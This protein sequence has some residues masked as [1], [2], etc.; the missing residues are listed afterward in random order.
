VTADRL[1]GEQTVRPETIEA[2]A[3]PAKD[4]GPGRYQKLRGEEMNELVFYH[5]VR[6]YWLTRYLEDTQPGLLRGLLREK[7]SHGV[8][9]G[10]VAAACGMEPG[11][12]WRN[13]DSVIVSHF[14]EMT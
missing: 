8:L 9:E 7:L 6:G 14:G 5:C 12:F 2:L 1:A 3:Q 10:K 4:T 13:I 11:E